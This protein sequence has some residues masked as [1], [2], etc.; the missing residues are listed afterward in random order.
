MIRVPKEVGHAPDPIQGLR[1]LPSGNENNLGKKGGGNLSQ[2][3]QGAL[4]L[5]RCLIAGPFYGARMAFPKT[6]A[7][8]KGGVVTNGRFRYAP[9]FVSERRLSKGQLGNTS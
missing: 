2:R 4:P 7:N 6:A 9:R 8:Q 3:T 1:A 5:K